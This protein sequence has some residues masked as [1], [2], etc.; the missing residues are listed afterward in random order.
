M[1]FKSPTFVAAVLLTVS[2]NA[3]AASTADL[4]VAGSITPGPCLPT[5]MGG[6]VI[7]YGEISASRLQGLD[8]FDLGFRAVTFNI[9]C[10]GPMLIGLAGIGQTNDSIARVN[11]Y[12]VFGGY[13][14]PDTSDLFG[15]GWTT[16]NDRIGAALATL[17]VNELDDQGNR[18]SAIVSTDG[19]NA[20]SGTSSG[21]LGA[22]Y[23]RIN[24]FA[25]LGS[26]A[27]RTV[28]DVSGRIGVSSIVSVTRSGL[29]DLNLKERIDIDG[30]LTLELVYL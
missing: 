11:Q 13:I 24:S 8:Y 26:L 15:L 9:K 28:S 21:Q 10:A 6:G 30:S 14:S 12:R 4:D 23:G 5:I 7:D 18:I 22:T 17:A 29:D 1:R 3:S 25:T 2:I 27:P 20:W 19:G 16:N